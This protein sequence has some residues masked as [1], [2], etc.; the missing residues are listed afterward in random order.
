MTGARSHFVQS[1][2]FLPLPQLVLIPVGLAS[3]VSYFVERHELVTGRQQQ[4]PAREPGKRNSPPQPGSPGRR[5]LVVGFATTLIVLIIVAVSLFVQF[6]REQVL[7]RELRELEPYPGVIVMDTKFERAWLLSNKAAV[8]SQYSTT[9]GYMAISEY[10]DALFRKE[11]WDSLPAEADLR[12][13][14]YCKGPYQARLEYPEQKLD[15]G[16][17]YAVEIRVD[18]CS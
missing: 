13:M 8:R 18:G 16:Y 17:R 3:I 9:A 14:R 6:R 5:S 2:A 1:T 15:P 7:T 10:Y 4:H 12:E 11:G